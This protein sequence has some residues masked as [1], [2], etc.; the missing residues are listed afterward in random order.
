MFLRLDNEP[1]KIIS[2]PSNKVFETGQIPH[3]VF[4]DEPTFHDNVDKFHVNVFPSHQS[5][6]FFPRGKHSIVYLARDQSFNT[7]KCT[8]TVQVDCK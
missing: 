1:P 7:I 3:Q 8:F 2:C 5:G 6:S 4:W